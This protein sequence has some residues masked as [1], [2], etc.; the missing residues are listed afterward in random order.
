MTFGSSPGLRRPILDDTATWRTTVD[1]EVIPVRDLDA[2][3]VVSIVLSFLLVAVAAV[4]L[5]PGAEPPATGSQTV[6]DPTPGDAPDVAPKDEAPTPDGRR[7]PESEFTVTQEGE[8]L[9]DVAVRIYG[10]A[11]A[12]ETLR[13]ANRD[14]LGPAGADLAPGTLLRTPEHPPGR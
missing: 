14:R 1:I 13:A 9:A 12:V 3:V 4:A 2:S 6:R 7:R 8:S 5:H 11:D 10:S